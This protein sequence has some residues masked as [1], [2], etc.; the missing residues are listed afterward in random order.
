M[1]PRCLQATRRRHSPPSNFPLPSVSLRPVLYREFYFALVQPS[2]HFPFALYLP[3]MSRLSFSAAVSRR[4]SRRRIPAGYSHHLHN[5]EY[6]SDF[7]PSICLCWC[8]RSVRVCSSISFCP[9]FSSVTNGSILVSIELD[10]NSHC[11][12]QVRH[13]PFVKT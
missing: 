11:L 10:S 7:L 4:V 5:R 2:Y 3:S 8:L 12:S 13:F 9:L 6:S 1:K